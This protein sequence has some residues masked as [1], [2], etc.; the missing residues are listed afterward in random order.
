MTRTDINKK[1]KDG[2][3]IRQMHQTWRG[4]SGKFAIQRTVK[5]DIFL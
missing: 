2:P 4:R 1:G 3:K 5:R